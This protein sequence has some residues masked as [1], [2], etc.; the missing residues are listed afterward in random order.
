[1]NVSCSSAYTAAKA[2]HDGVTKSR[3]CPPIAF[4]RFRRT[5]PKATLTTHRVYFV[6]ATLMSFNLQGFSPS[7]DP[8]PSPVL[9]LPC[10]LDFQAS[11]QAGTTTKVQ[12]LCKSGLRWRCCH[13]QKKTHP[14]LALIPSE[15]LPF[16]AVETSFL[17]SSS[18]ALHSF[19]E[20]RPFSTMGTLESFRQRTSFTVFYPKINYRYRPL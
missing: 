10:R 3:Q 17:A 20:P 9:I 1:M 5:S 12:S 7:R 16:V 19:E 15:A 2:R 4:L 18:Y 6:P 14:L 11:S 8:E 13:S